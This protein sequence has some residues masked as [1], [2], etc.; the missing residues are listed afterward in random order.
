MVRPTRQRYCL[1]YLALQRVR[2]GG[3]RYH[4]NRGIP[5]VVLNPDAEPDA[6]AIMSLCR[7]QLAAYKAPR[8]IQFVADLPKTSTGK[9]IRRELRKL[10]S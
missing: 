9:I 5:Y 2:L 3:D 4:G 6:D 10:D 7:E 1:G 8:L